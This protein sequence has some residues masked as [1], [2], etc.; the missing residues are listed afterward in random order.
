MLTI[1]LNLNTV[2]NVDEFC[3]LRHFINADFFFVFK[4]SRAPNRSWKII[5]GSPGKSWKSPGF[6][7]S[8]RVG[9][10]LEAVLC[11]CC[12]RS[13]SSRTMSAGSPRTGTLNSRDVHHNQLANMSSG[14]QVISAS[15]LPPLTLSSLATSPYQHHPAAVQPM[16][17]SPPHGLSV[18]QS[19]S[20]S[21]RVLSPMSLSLMSSSMVSPTVPVV[22]VS[23]QS[24]DIHS[25]HTP[26]PAPGDVYFLS[27]CL[28]DI[29]PEPDLAGIRNSPA[30]AGARARFVESLFSDHRTIHLV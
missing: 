16:F 22:A 17:S 18:R 10:L 4:H 26:S 29:R 20:S 24:P 6:F 13:T 12:C 2:W 28:F 30:G 23:S 7:V 9:T 21:P 19:T 27:H 3:R 15:P 1:L 25:Q 5:Q 14:S 8:K 11:F